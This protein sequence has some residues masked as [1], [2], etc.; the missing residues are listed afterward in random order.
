[1]SFN[2]LIATLGRPS[3]QRMLDSL[4][5]QLN[6][7]DCLTIVFD[8]HSE[9][10][11]FDLSKFNCSIKQ[12]FEP[13]ALG[14]WGHAIRNKY[15]SVLDKRDFVMHA[16]DDDIYLPNVFAELRKQCLDT[17]TLYIAKMYLSRLNRVIPEGNFIKIN[18]IGTPNGIIPYDL[19]RLQQWKYQYGGDG[20][21]YESLSRLSH[22][23]VF[24]PTVIYQV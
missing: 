21:F 15:A 9:I 18:H 4:S 2:I 7:Q 8:G 11:V 19:N 5:S 3:L 6:Q 23:T 1:M 20:L 22:K 16:D 12:Y 14:S 17:H 13:V 24:L 10:P